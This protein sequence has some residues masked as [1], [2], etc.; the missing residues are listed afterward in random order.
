M[1]FYFKINSLINLSSI[2]FDSLSLHFVIRLVIPCQTR[3]ELPSISKVILTYS[4]STARE[5]PTFATKHFSPTMSTT[6]AHE[7][8]F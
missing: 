6:T 7:P 2:L 8:D 1:Q 4:D 3:D 5:S